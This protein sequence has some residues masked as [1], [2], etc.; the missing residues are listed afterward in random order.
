MTHLND[1]DHSAFEEM[2]DFWI[3]LTTTGL[4]SLYWGNGDKFR[5]RNRNANSR[6]KFSMKSNENFCFVHRPYKW[7]AI[8]CS[9]EKAFICQRHVLLKGWLYPILYI[10]VPIF[11]L[12]FVVSV[13]FLRNKK[14]EVKMYKSRLSC[15]DS[16]M[17]TP[18]FEKETI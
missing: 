1:S 10:L 8:K 4:K 13:L 12:V 5:Y 2:N 9:Q 18:S 17:Y 14:N 15:T 6:L 16:Y 3:G 7:R 11:V